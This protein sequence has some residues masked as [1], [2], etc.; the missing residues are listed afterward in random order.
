MQ[1]HREAF[2]PVH[3]K[4]GQVFV[5]MLSC[6]VSPSQQFDVRLIS[7]ACRDCAERT[8]TTWPDVDTCGVLMGG[9]GGGEA[10]GPLCVGWGRAVARTGLG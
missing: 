2:V 1:G 3:G 4:T 10:D 7:C 9:G 5:C 8:P 6:F